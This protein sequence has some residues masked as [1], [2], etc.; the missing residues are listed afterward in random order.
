[1][2][3]GLTKSRIKIEL[4]DSLEGISG[5]EAV[6]GFGSYFRE[7]PFED[8]DL[9]VVFTDACEDPLA[10]YEQTLFRLRALEA[11]LGVHLHVTPLTAQ[12]FKA[13]PLRE[14]DQLAPLLWRP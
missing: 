12:E 6:F 2:N 10:V 11:R 5:I 8:I 4:S 7:E 1:M 9:A 13:R 14:H 3:S